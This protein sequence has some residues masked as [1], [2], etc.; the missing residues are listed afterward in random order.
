MPKSFNVRKPSTAKQPSFSHQNRK[1]AR[2]KEKKR[3]GGLTEESAGLEAVR[4][5]ELMRLTH[6]SV[7]WEQYSWYLSIYREIRGIVRATDKLTE[8]LTVDDVS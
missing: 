3:W 2:R 5:K 1:K 8:G 4:R 6:L 7:P